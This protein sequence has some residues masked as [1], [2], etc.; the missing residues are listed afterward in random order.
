MYIKY[1]YV[2]LDFIKQNIKKSHNAR[3]RKIYCNNNKQVKKKCIVR[4]LSETINMFQPF[5]Y[6]VY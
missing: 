6:T 2:F 5:I 3:G 4:D 1:L